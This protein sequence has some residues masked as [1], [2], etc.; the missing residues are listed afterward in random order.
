MRYEILLYEF[1]KKKNSKTPQKALQ[2]SA[3]KAKEIPSASGLGNRKQ[4]KKENGEDK[5]INFENFTFLRNHII[6]KFN[7]LMS[8]QVLKNTIEVSKF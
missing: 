2:R 7:F 6:E 5:E 3:K 1:E 4:K 8:F